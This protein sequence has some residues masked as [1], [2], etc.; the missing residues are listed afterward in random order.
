[1]PQM[2]R[3]RYQ[4][5]DPSGIH[6]RPAAGR[7]T[8]VSTEGF[9]RVYQK[10]SGV[11]GLVDSLPGIL[12]GNTFRQVVEAV[13]SAKTRRRP[14]IWGLGAHVI[15]CG[16][17][18][19]LIDLMRRDLVTAI[20]LNGAGA[21]HD[22]EICMTGAT[23][24]DVDKEL[25]EGQFGMV[26]ETP[27]WMNEAIL[28][29]SATDLGLGESM[30]GYILEHAG[31]FPHRDA[32]L[33]ASAF[34]LGIPVTV[35]VAIGTDT[36]HNHPSTD[37]AALGKTSLR[38][39]RLFTA[40]VRELNEGGVYLNCGSAVILP[41]VFLK[42]VSLV[43]NLKYPLGNF[44]TVNLDFLQHYRPHQ[45]VLKRPTSQSGRGLSLTGHHEILLPLLAAALIEAGT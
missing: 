29:G 16:L 43:R 31:R 12:A 18:P 33:L 14:I 11:I 39:F 17:N 5:I 9:A 22:L 26:Q 37:G 35:H 3:Y 25:E 40:I 34:E 23:S 7:A 8:K 2:S 4:P 13:R 1:M 15:K 38:D 45:N 19:V 21:I 41:E 30:G 27:L 10:G 36:V 20:A 6:T 44:T 32:S 28:T 42:A 24:E